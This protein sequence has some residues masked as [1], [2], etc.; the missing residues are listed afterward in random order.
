MKDDIIGGIQNSVGNAID[1]FL[2]FGKE[3]SVLQDVLLTVIVPGVGILIS[4][5]AVR[6]FMRMKNPVHQNKVSTSSV[7]IRF[8]IGPATVQLVI[9]MRAMA[10]SVFGREVASKSTMKALSYSGASTGGDPTAALLIV[11]VSFLIFVGWVTALRAMLAFSRVGHP[12]ENGYQMFRSGA[13]RLVAAT[14][15]CMF[16]FA[17]DDVIASFTGNTGVF[18]SQ[19]TL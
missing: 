4:A 3:I 15:L 5:G 19:L 13:A 10:E 14:F 11:I 7:A 17:L 8:V 18:S 9:L 6:D 12:Q 1:Y 2:N 16:Q